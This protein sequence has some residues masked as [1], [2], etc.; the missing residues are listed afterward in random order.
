MSFTEPVH[1]I[2]CGLFLELE[3]LA[4]GKMDTQL[5]QILPHCFSEKLVHFTF[6]PAIR[7][8]VPFLISLPTFGVMC[9]SKFS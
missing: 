1:S 4:P 7:E 9:S 5:N 8:G 6:S 3:F 2:F